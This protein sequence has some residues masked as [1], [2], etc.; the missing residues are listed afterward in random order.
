MEIRKKYDVE[1]I[2]TTKLEKN[3][4]FLEEEKQQLTISINKLQD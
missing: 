2:K 4:A 3:I 1:K